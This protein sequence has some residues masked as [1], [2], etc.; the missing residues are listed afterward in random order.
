[1]FEKS[2]GQLL[3]PQDEITSRGAAPIL[4]SGLYAVRSFVSTAEEQEQLYVLYWPEDT[5]WDDQAVN[6]VQGNRVMFMR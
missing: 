5:T 6:T 2:A 3:M 4:R 1:L